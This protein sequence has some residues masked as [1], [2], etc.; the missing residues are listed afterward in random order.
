[1]TS[2]KLEQDSWDCIQMNGTGFVV[3]KVDG[4]ERPIFWL[5]THLQ[6]AFDRGGIYVAR[7][8]LLLHTGAPLELDLSQLAHG[9]DWASCYVPSEPLSDSA[10][11]R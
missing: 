4:E 7:R 5:P 6:H 10:R 3:V 1:M 8:N 9:R 11:S 2:G